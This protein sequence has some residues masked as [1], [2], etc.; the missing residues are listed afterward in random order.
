M[1]RWRVHHCFCSAVHGKLL[2]GKAL[3]SSNIFHRMMNFKFSKNSKWRINFLFNARDLKLGPFYDMLFSFRAFFKLWPITNWVQGLYWGILAWGCG[4]M[5]C[6]KRGPYKNNR[7]TI[8]PRAGLVSSL[9]YGTQ[10]MLILNLPAFEKKK[11][12]VYDR[13][14]G[15]SPY[16]EIPIKKEPIRMLG[17]TSRLPCHIIIFNNYYYSMSAHW[18]WDGK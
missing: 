3:L 12:T 11:Y 9:L 16:G 5:D 10:A 13:F 7:G 4:S 17:F 6:A 1:A 18:I 14:L 2:E 8:F 15:N